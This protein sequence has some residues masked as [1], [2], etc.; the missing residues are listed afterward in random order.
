MQ[1]KY[2]QEK[3]INV[4]NQL[5]IEKNR[6]ERNNLFLLVVL[7]LAIAGLIYIY[8]RKLLY[9]ERDI[10][11][12]KEQLQIHL[13]KL[14]ENESI[15]RKNKDVIQSLSDQLDGSSDLQDH[16]NDQMSEIELICRKNESLQQ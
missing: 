16:L 11:A 1:A 5:V 3:L 8:Q 13:I 15:I 12:T 7:L 10:Q 2:D 14:R 6:I 4:N 9:K